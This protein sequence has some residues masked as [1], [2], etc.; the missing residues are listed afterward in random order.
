MLNVLMRRKR[1]PHAPL[2][3]AVAGWDA[4]G[5]EE[6]SLLQTKAAAV[7]EFQVRDA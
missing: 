2:K 3:P 4:E 6:G 1:R 5:E 7:S